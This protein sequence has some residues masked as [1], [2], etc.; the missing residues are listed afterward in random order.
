MKNVNKMLA[1]AEKIVW[2][3]IEKRVTKILLSDRNRA[4]SFVCCMGGYFWVD[5][6]GE[7]MDDRAWQNPVFNIFDKYDDVFKLS[8]AGV[9]WD[10]VNGEVVKCNDW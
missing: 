6:D 2:A 7:P 10:L 1:E 4:A 5:R 9:R 8:G 3:E